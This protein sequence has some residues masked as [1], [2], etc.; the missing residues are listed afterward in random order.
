MKYLNFGLFNKYIFIKPL[1]FA[2][3]I[4]EVNIQYPMNNHS[5]HELKNSIIERRENCKIK[6]KEAPFNLWHAI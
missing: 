5:F 6:G 4:W 1:N 3:Q 2:E